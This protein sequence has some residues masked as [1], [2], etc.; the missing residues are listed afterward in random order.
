MKFLNIPNIILA[1]VFASSS[2]SSVAAHPQLK[3]ADIVAMADGVMYARSF[4]QELE[5]KA[6]RDCGYP[7]DIK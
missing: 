1:V 4:M 5:S 6:K 2:L 7:V 3:D